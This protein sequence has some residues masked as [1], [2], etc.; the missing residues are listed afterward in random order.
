M[1]I[2]KAGVAILSGFGLSW[3]LY[4]LTATHRIPQLFGLATGCVLIDLTLWL[5]WRDE[6]TIARSFVAQALIGLGVAA[7]RVRLEMRAQ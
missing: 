5:L 2:A 1:T 4:P 3:L 7:N 6:E